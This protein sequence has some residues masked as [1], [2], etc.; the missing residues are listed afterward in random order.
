MSGLWERSVGAV[1]AAVQLATCPLLL[2]SGAAAQSAAYFSPTFAASEGSP[3]S[4]IYARAFGAG[5]P[6]SA[7]HPAPAAPL[8]TAAPPVATPPDTGVVPDTGVIYVIE[9]G[10]LLTVDARD[11]ARGSATAL[12]TA[13]LPDSGPAPGAPAAALPGI[14]DRLYGAPPLE[15]A[16][17]SGTPAP[18]APIR[19][20]PPPN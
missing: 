10:R 18:G 3:Y 15:T 16:A 17:G 11:Y 5:G 4:D 6:P 8:V 19:L 20:V 1:F 7:A 9:G 2:P 12:S 13:P 14:A